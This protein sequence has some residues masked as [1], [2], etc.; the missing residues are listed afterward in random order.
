MTVD[1]DDTA[2]LL[3]AKREALLNQ[4]DAVDKALAALTAAGITAADASALHATEP[5]EEATNAV[6][7]TR[8]T[9]RR[10]LSDEHRHALAEGRRKAHHAKEAAA[11][12]AR[13][14]IDPAPGLAPAPTVT[15]L[16]RLVKRQTSS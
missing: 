11:G 8:V 14:A 12:R 7:L 6:V 10:I 16:P 9:P 15:E 5:V 2:S 13:E 3:R 1:I 4:L